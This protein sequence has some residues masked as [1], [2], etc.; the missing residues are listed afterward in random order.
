MTF[1]TMDG[2]ILWDADAVGWTALYLLRLLPSGVPYRFYF[3][4]LARFHLK[5]GVIRTLEVGVQ[6][7]FVQ[8]YEF[9]LVVTTDVVV[10][11]SDFAEIATSRI[12]KGSLTTHED[13]PL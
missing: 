10:I 13:R 2:A 12:G 6:Y 8:S 4:I 11:R 7:A 5:N 9:M 1:W 3:V